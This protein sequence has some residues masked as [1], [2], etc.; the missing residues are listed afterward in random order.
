MAVLNIKSKNLRSSI[1]FVHDILIYMLPEF[2]IV[3]EI[4]I[5]RILQFYDSYMTIVQQLLINQNPEI[6]V[7]FT[8][9]D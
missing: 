2:E 5:V 8:N 3:F 1:T 7:Q 4:V 6:W 9:S